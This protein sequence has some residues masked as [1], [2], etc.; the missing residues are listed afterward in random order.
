MKGGIDDPDALDA[1]MRK[2]KETADKA[3]AEVKRMAEQ[4]AREL[5][6]G[7]QGEPLS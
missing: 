4:L 2:M 7:S 1:W 3:S 6:V 5:L